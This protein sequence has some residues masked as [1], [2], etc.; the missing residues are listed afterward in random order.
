MTKLERIVRYIDDHDEQWLFFFAY[1]ALSIYLSFFLNLGFFVILLVIHVLLDFLKH[2]HSSNRK[3]N[4]LR[5]AFVYAVRDGL[6]FDLFLLLLAFIF[7]Y[8]FEATLAVG[9]SKGV[10]LANSPGVRAFLRAVPRVFLANWVIENIVVLTLYLNEHDKK[11]TYMAVK[12]TRFEKV[13]VSLMGVA[14]VA[15]FFLPPIFGESYSHL[16]DYAMRELVPRIGDFG[17]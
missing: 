15:L 2:L 5:H 11:K 8:I 1:L 7:G 6:V 12:M 4:Q 14:L 17:S 13:I 10:K 16:V 9:L 3:T